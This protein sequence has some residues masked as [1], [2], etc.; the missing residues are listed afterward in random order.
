MATSRILTYIL[1]LTILLCNCIDLKAY[2]PANVGNYIAQHKAAA[3]S[4]EKDYG[5]PATIILAQGILESGAGT[6]GLTRASNNHFGIKA[7]KSWTGRVLPSWDD[8]LVMSKFR[9]YASA[10][11]SYR[12]HAKLLT[13]NQ[14][15]KSLFNISIYDYRGWAHGLK[16]A[17]YA[18]APDYA[19][20][21]IGIIDQYRL[22]EIN[23]G[24][25]LKP[26]KTVTV[27]RY[28]EVE[29][30]IF[31]EA[32]IME[33]EEES[34]EQSIIHNSMNHY[35]VE[36]NNL[37]CTVM[38]PGETFASVL[39]KYDVSPSDILSFNE[40][41]SERHIK[42]GDI[43]FLEKKRKKYQGYQDVHLCK[44]GDTLY[45]IS[46][47]YGI[48]LHSLAKLNKINDYARL[49]EGKK[50]YLK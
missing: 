4:N 44:S 39:R 18:T 7:G 2:T 15:Y 31:D 24:V 10:A 43:I 32:C 9:C 46:Q 3:L 16:R 27:I 29:K 50:I 42:E 41:A 28:K 37:R 5:I 34:E 30:P 47:T 8:E 26:G 35:V 20:A 48:Q 33:E 14:R 38:Q 21:L 40:V 13:T 17:G 19:E 6:S 36:I 1:S 49:E 22:Y 11:E 23:G 25:K 12:D 45:K